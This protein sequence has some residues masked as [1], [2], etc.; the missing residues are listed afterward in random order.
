MKYFAGIDP[1]LSG[2]LALFT[3]EAN[4]PIIEIFD[5]PTFTIT[6]NKS[7]KRQIDLHSLGE[8]FNFHCDSILKVTIENPSAMP[9]QGV[10]SVFSFGFSCGVVQGMAAVSRIPIFLARP[11]A[12]KG[13]LGLTKDKDASRNL[14]SKMFPKHTSKWNLKKHDGRAEA[15]LLAYYGMMKK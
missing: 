8:W 10:T 11:A 12:W 1:G 9:E 3:L 14:A 15:V 5:M 6:K 4:S 7:Q 2:A 13:D